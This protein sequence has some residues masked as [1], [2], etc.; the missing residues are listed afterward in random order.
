M[1]AAFITGKQQLE[2]RSVPTPE[3]KPGEVRIRV[4]YVGICGSDLHYFFEGANGPNV[5]K[6]P[7]IPGHELSG[8]VDLDPE[9]EWE[10]DTP[11][12]VHPARFGEVAEDFSDRPHLWPG[13]SYLGSAA[14]L[15][16]TQGA[17]AEY[18]IVDRGMVRTL[19]HSLS[20]RR[21]V[22]AEPL[23]VA[24]HA[25]NQAGALD[26]KRVLVAGAGP[27]G[28]L[29]IAAARAGGASSVAATD[30]LPGPL[31][32]ARAAGADACFNVAAEEVP[33]GFDVV[34]ECTGVPASVS[35]AFGV[36]RSAGTVVLVGM[37]SADPQPVALAPI[38]TR[39]LTVVGSF[40]FNNEIDAALTFLDA[41]PGVE[42]T[43]THELEADDSASIINALEVA[44][45]SE[46]SGKV[47]LHLWPQ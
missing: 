42:E 29:T 38:G 12:T 24:L 35:T 10:T 22:L 21:A 25:L 11:V 33:P 16:H 36:T 15:P 44:R 39:E 27:I 3:P 2:I 30:V 9:G 26:G 40:R 45:D 31:R 19:P 5:I 1:R 23:G 46:Q 13:G 7:L 43:I 18:L 6:E 28:L 47:V 4:D 17:L 8:R 14:T 32:R 34:F 41:H 20:I 37:M